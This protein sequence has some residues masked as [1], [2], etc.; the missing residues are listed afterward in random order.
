MVADGGPL[1]RED[2]YSTAD[3]RAD[4]IAGAPALYTLDDVVAQ[5]AIA[6]AD[7]IGLWRALGFPLPAKGEVAFSDADVDAIT[8]AHE[9]VLYGVLGRATETS[10][11][12]AVSHTA[13]RLV[14]WQF[15][16]LVD[17]AANRFD[18]D[19][20]SARMVVLDQ[21]A[22]LAD[23]FADQIMYAWRKHLARLIRQIGHKIADVGPEVGEPDA[24]EHFPLMRAV[25]FV[26]LVGFTAFSANL[27]ARELDGLVQEFSEK[28]RDLV[29]AGGGRVVKEMG[30]GV[31]YVTDEPIRAALI[32]LDLVET[33]GKDSGRP[34][35]RVGLTWGRVLGRY[36]DV[37]GPCVNL[38]SRLTTL[39]GA[40]EVLV[41]AATGELLEEEPELRLVR[42]PK[43]DLAGLGS[44]R[45]FRLERRG[46]KPATPVDL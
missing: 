24:S 36:G 3:E 30:D 45:S 37:F 6:K 19:T 35:A 28:S 23:I 2:P 40:R 20:Q 29:T 26:D 27:D 16:S 44:V 46:P 17:D 39:A 32:A 1:Q 18:L 8:A 41:D 13:E 15:E 21:I 9:V 31:M 11:L 5:T 12:R 33:V 10:L 25:A 38:A 34:P 7:V 14:W 42:R 4:R 43:A 22:D